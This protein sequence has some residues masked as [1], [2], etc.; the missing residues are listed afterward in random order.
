MTLDVNS[1]ATMGAVMR[2]GSFAAAAREL[3]YTPSAVSQQMSAL[4]R[5]LGIRLF[6]REPRRVTPTEAAHYVQERSEQVIDLLGQLEVDLARLGAGETGR[7]RVGTFDSAG[8]PIMGQAI[9]RFLVRR[10]EV[11]ITLDEGEPYELFPRVSDGGLDLA[12]GFQYDLVP[13]KFPD[14]LRLSEVMTEDLYVV[15]HRK[16]RLAGRPSVR[17]E[18]LHGETWVAHREETPSHHCLQEL[19]ARSGFRPEIAFRSNNLGTVKGIVAAGLAVAMIPQLSYRPDEDDVVALPIAE[20]MPRRQ[21]VA[22]TRADDANPLTAAFLGA[23]RRV[24]LP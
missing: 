15:A 24:A 9:A 4:E 10:R 3:G 13:R 2:T 14:N 19:C 17:L 1:L 21:I 23:M 11:Q 12:L 20:T 18:E 8:G 22:A 7:L 5:S 16:H 6:D